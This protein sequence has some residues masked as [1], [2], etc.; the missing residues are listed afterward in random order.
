MLS[1]P[2][3]LNPPSPTGPLVGRPAKAGHFL[4]VYN[5]LVMDIRLIYL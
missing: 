3:H 1:Y 4:A 2:F 5:A